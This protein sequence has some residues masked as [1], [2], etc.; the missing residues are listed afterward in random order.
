MTS[1]AA[2]PLDNPGD[3]FQTPSLVELWR[4]APYMHD[5]HYRTVKEIFTED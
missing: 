3:R 1:A 2:G 4:T 5:G